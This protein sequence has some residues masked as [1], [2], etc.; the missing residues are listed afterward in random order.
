MLC[1]LNAYDMTLTYYLLCDIRFH[2]SLN[3]I[4]IAWSTIHDG[5]GSMF[6]IKDKINPTGTITLS[7]SLLLFLP[8]SVDDI[9]TEMILL[10]RTFC[11]NTKTTLRS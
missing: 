7:L 10:H 3:T 1:H 8:A 9:Y 5:E 6:R 2:Y 11:Y 4:N